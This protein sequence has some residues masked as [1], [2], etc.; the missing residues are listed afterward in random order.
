[1]YL[2]SLFMIGIDKLLLTSRGEERMIELLDRLSLKDEIQEYAVKVLGTT[3]RANKQKELSKFNVFQ[4]IKKWWFLK[5]K[6]YYTVH[7]R[8]I[9][10]QFIGT[11]KSYQTNDSIRKELGFIK[12]GL[13]KI[14]N[15]IE[16]IAD[17]YNYKRSQA[18]QSTESN[19]MSSGE[20]K[21]M[22]EENKHDESPGSTPS[23]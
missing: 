14:D 23:K 15:D 20:N 22:Y 13:K 18:N 2:V 1:M 16:L 19:S 21:R 10:R 11:Y 17:Y 9:T 4:R 6:R 7:F 8:Q 12:E 5:K 3:Y